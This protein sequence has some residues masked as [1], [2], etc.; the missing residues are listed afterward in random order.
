MRF[1]HSRLEFSAWVIRS[2]EFAVLFF[3][4]SSI[5]ELA[6]TSAMPCRD[7]I[8]AGHE[9]SVKRVNCHGTFEFDGTADTEHFSH[10]QL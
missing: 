3:A 7:A 8:T 4:L 1:K 5:A 2:N 6:C 9:K 10:P